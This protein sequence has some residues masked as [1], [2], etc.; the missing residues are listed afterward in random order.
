MGGLLVSG[1]GV[2][3][4]TI[5]GSCI[6][7][8]LYDPQGR[9]GGMNHFLLPSE[10]HPGRCDRVAR[11][12]AHSM[13]L[14]INGILKLGG[15]RA[16][17]VAKVFG[18]ANV[19]KGMKSPTV[20][21]MNIAFVR[22]YLE[23]EGIP[24]LGQ[25]LGGVLPLQVVFHPTTGQVYVRPIHGEASGLEL[26]REYEFLRKAPVKLAEPQGTVELFED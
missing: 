4:K 26:K 8:C 20:G 7:A 1:Q 16:G 6:A 14:L 17:L 15:R 22:E 11:F 9:V 19:L 23:A 21:E 13:E 3:L 18:G 5:L 10:A 2:Y 25:R 12:G 24:L